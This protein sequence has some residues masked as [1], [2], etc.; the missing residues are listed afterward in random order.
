MHPSLGLGML[1]L[2]FVNGLC[3]VILTIVVLFVTH[4]SQRAAISQ[5]LYSELSQNLQRAYKPQIVV[6]TIS[7]KAYILRK[8]SLELQLSLRNMIGLRKEL[9]D[10][11]TLNLTV[12]LNLRVKCVE[13]YKFL[14]CC[15]KRRKID[16]SS[17]VTFRKVE[18]L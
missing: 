4:I 13:S 11:N 14:P 16:D 2:D 17:D 12:R 8:T 5:N 18:K 10:L 6:T 15:V 3:L 1:C 9:A 7:Y